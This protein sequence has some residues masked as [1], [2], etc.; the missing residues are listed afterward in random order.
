MK[1][2]T[3]IIFAGANGS[4]KT[5]VARAL[6]PKVKIN[7]FVNADNIAFGLSPMNPTGQAMAAGRLV[8]KRI[9]ELTAK[10]VSFAIETTLSG[11]AQIKKL[12]VAKA[13]GYSI[14]MHYIFCRDINLNIKRVKLRA[15]Q[16]G[17]D[18]PVADIRRRYWR[19]LK[20]YGMYYDLCD[21]IRVYDTSDGNPIEIA[22]KCVEKLY[23]QFDHKRFSDFIRKIIEAED[24]H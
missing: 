1:K 16:G 15:K 22:D 18:V 2:P 10:G 19:S 24:E 9:D 12:R 11:T 14:E 7:E 17:H 23:I 3:L 4:G 6:L 20:N 13:A 5:T 21:K 8:S